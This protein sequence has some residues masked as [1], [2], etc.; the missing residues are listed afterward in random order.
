MQCQYFFSEQLL[1]LG[2]FPAEPGEFRVR[3]IHKTT[4]PVHLS[5]QLSGLYETRGR[6]P[7]LDFV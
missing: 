5:A 7:G 3:S 4:L 1:G 6:K 2:E